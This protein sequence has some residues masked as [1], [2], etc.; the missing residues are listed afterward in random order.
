M[1][2]RK[3]LDS[4]IHSSSVYFNRCIEKLRLWLDKKSYSLNFETDAHDSVYYSSKEVFIDSRS[5][6]E[7]KLY[8]LLHECGHILIE[9]SGRNRLYNLS[10]QV[11]PVMGQRV[12]RKKK[13]A[14]ISEE[15][16]AWK[17]GESL[18]RKLDI[19]INSGKFDKIRADAIMSYIE[20]ARD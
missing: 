6:P 13:V 11:E 4:K 9:N 19:K 12:N 17:R 1:A 3:K 16:E 2:G 14:V 7:K 5:H 10:Q 8:I 15:I 18:A 20:W